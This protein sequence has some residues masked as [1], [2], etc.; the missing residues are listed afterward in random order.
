MGFSDLP[1]VWGEGMLFAYSGWD[2]PTNAMSGFV[3]ATGDRPYHLL[4]HTPKQRVLAIDLPSA[5]KVRIATGDVLRV[6]A[7]SGEL[8][9]AYAAWHSL[10]GRLPAGSSVW[11]SFLRGPEE[12]LRD[13]ADV[14]VDPEAP[15]ALALVRRADRFALS[16]G[17]MPEQAIQRAK[18][19]LDED[20]AAHAR[21]LLRIYHRV[22]R[23]GDPGKQRLLNK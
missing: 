4:F 21:K 5:G 2:G 16:Y 18:A 22:P 3:G 9:L 10:I 17:T 12:Q 6:E 15:D 13:N 11:L 19:A 8:F 14:C 7:G 1:D 20:V 23:V